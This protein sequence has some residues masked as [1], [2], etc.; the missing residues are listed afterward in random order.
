[1]LHIRRFTRRNLKSTQPREWEQR[2]VAATA[3]GRELK[4]YENSQLPP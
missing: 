3:V 2:G 4:S 1:M